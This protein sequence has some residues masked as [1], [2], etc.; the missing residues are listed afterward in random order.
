[1]ISFSKKLKIAQPLNYSYSQC[2]EDI[3]VKRILG[4]LG[5]TKATYLDIGANDPVNLNNT[6]LFY[7]LGGRGVLVEPDPTICKQI[8]RLR[9][10]DTLINAGIG[11]EQQGKA[12]FYIFSNNVLNTFS[13]TEA[14]YVD[15]QGKNNIQKVIDVPLFTI[16]QV[17]DEYFASCPNFISIDIEGMDYEV[18][19]SLDF[20]QYRPEVFCIETISYT[21]DNTEEKINE[22]FNLMQSK[23]YLLYGDTYINSIFVDKSKW[24]NR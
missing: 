7:T 19:N 10:Q 13:Q 4:K 15:K 11:V 8:G 24:L 1:M 20:L 21:E 14:E 22:I 3:M 18:I 2:G 17:I 5:I 6:Y 9:N 12:S 23:D 16:N